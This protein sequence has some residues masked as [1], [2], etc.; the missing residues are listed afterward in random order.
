MK[1]SCLWYCSSRWW[2]FAS[3]ASQKWMNHKQSTIVKNNYI[4][5][6]KIYN[7]KKRCW[8]LHYSLWYCWLHDYMTWLIS[9]LWKPSWTEQQTKFNKLNYSFQHW[10]YD[11]TIKINIGS[12]N[13]VHWVQ[14]L[15]SPWFFQIHC[16]QLFFLLFWIDFVATVKQFGIFSDVGNIGNKMY[17]IINIFIN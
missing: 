9:H 13:L 12:N 11:T 7:L 6:S 5:P 1:L 10:F 14:P 2:Y 15:N 3:L 16:F 17:S 4:L 8:S